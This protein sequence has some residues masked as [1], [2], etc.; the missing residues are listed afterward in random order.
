MKCQTCQGQK[1]MVTITQEKL[2]EKG[3]LVIHNVPAEKCEC[4]IKIAFRPLLMIEDFSKKMSEDIRFMEYEQ[5]E[6]MYEHVS[7]DNLI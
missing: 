3:K 5:L 7:T 4:D 1:Q 6:K 2:T